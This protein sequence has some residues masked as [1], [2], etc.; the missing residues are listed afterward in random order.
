MLLPFDFAW[1]VLMTDL[2]LLSLFIRTT[3]QI[4]IHTSNFRCFSIFFKS[5]STILSLFTFIGSL[6]AHIPQ[7][8]STILIHLPL[9]VLDLFCIFSIHQLFKTVNNDSSLKPQLVSYP[10]TV[11]ISSWPKSLKLQCTK[12]ASNLTMTWIEYG[13]E[14]SILCI[15]MNFKFPISIIFIFYYIYIMSHTS[16]SVIPITAINVNIFNQWRTSFI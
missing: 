2:T 8:N 4:I 14:N 16:F 10:I 6:N 12:N 7:P 11:C 1:N 3:Y 13:Y 9:G 15:V 5:I